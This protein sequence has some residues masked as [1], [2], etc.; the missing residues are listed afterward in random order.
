MNLP[1]PGISFD[2]LCNFNH[3][4]NSMQKEQSKR[5]QT[6]ILNSAEKKVLLWLAE[7]QPGWMTSDILTVIGVIGAVVVAAGYVLSNYNIMWLWLSTFGFFVNWYGDSLDG[8]LARYRKTQ[9]PIY[10]FYLD[11]TVDGM[12]MAIMCIGAGLSDMLNLYIAFAVLVVYLLLSISVY[13]NAHLK[14]EFK[15][16]YA[17]MGPTEFRLILMV[18]N[19]LFIYIRPLREYVRHIS[20][21]GTDVSFGSFDFIGVAILL[22]LVVIYFENFI[23]DARGYAKVDP[24][25]KWDGNEMERN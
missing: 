2:V 12:T 14:G 11:H 9:R 3:N 25:K 24:L 10:G 1:V 19:T 23:C 16:T 6:S 5:I 15:L 18:V 21:L 17:G 20:I 4:H 8:T 13:I 7:R 22:I